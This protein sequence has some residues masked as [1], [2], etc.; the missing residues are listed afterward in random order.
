MRLIE[1]K[2]KNTN[3][4]KNSYLKTSAGVSVDSV[5]SGLRLKISP[6]LLKIK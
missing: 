2:N 3:E 5:T 4:Q 6:A 1:K